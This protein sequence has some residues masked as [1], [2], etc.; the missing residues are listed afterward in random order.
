MFHPEELR[1]EAE[2]AAVEPGEVAQ[3]V[4]SPRCLFRCDQIT[5]ADADAHEDLARF[6]LSVEVLPVFAPL[7]SFDGQP[8]DEERKQLAQAHNARELDECAAVN[9]VQCVELPARDYANR[10]LK[11]LKVGQSLALH[12]RNVSDEAARFRAVLVGIGL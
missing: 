5:A 9:A 4:V 6:R 1:L 8:L 7:V 10:R 12:V 3:I 11:T 2:S